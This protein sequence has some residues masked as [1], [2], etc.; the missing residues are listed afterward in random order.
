MKELASTEGRKSEVEKSLQKLAGEREVFDQLATAFGRTGVQALL[1]EAAIPDLEA[2]ANLLLGRM[3]DNTMNVKLETQRES[4]RGETVETLEIKVSDA[5]GTRSY[6]TFSGGEAF[7]INLALRISLSKLLARRAGAPLPTLFIDEGFG[8]QDAAGRERVLDV[9]Q[10]IS[11][12]FERI[13]VITH[14]D[15]VR[16]AFPVRIEVLKTPEGSTFTLT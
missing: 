7:R 8:T 10:S 12:D 5:L 16:D 15:E 9:I 1:V 14:M 11:D 6:E 3:T 13:L 4:Q 2:E